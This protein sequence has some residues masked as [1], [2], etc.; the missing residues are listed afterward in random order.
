MQLEVSRQ[1]FE[2]YSNPKFRE[3]PSSGSRVVKY[4]QTD[5]HDEAHSRFSQLYERA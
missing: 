4:G 1:I 3:H 2:K 5:S